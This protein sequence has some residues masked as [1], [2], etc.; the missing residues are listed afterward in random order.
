M[1]KRLRDETI[2]E[3]GPKIP[4][5][6]SLV[7]KSSLWDEVLLILCF[8]FIY[9]LI[10]FPISPLFPGFSC[11]GSHCSQWA[12]DQG[13]NQF[14]DSH[15]LSLLLKYFTISKSLF[16][17]GTVGASEH[18]ISRTKMM[19]MSSKPLTSH[20]FGNFLSSEQFWAC[21]QHFTTV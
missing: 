3:M 17:R 2:Q 9:L 4:G 1:E 8:I 10:T 13:W 7:A 19:I 14:W 18:L 6:T 16:S 21:L 20:S 5:D 12:S 15:P 11:T